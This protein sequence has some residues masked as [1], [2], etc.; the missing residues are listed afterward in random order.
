MESHSLFRVPKE[1]LNLIRETEIDT[2][3]AKTEKP[4]IEHAEEAKSCIACQITTFD[5]IDDRKL[6]FKTDWHRYNLNQRYCLVFNSFHIIL[7]YTYGIS[8]LVL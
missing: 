4:L 6:H 7:I 3:H 8:F 5:S 1:V 2:E